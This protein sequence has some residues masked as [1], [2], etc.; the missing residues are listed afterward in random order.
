MKPKRVIAAL[1]F[2]VPC[3]IASCSVGSGIQYGSSRELVKLKG[4]EINE[5]SGLACGKINKGV[6]WTHNDSG[7]KPRIFAIDRSGRTLATVNIRNAKAVDWEDM[8]S[9]M[10]NGKS[11]LLLGDTGDNKGT[12]KCVTLYL[13]EEPK[14]DLKKFNRKLTI[15]FKQKINF[16]YADGPDDCEAVA[17]DP[18]DKVVAIVTKGKK[19]LYLLKLKIPAKPTDETFVLQCVGKLDIPSPT[20]MDISPDARRAVVVTYLWG[21]EYTREANESWA[22]AFKRSPQT[23]HLPLR[24]QGETI[25]FGP[26]GRNLYLT[27]EKTPTPLIEIP[28][29]QKAAPHKSPVPLDNTTPN[30]QNAPKSARESLHSTPQIHKDK[31]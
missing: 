7:D 25:C 12:R 29:K 30:K 23:I 14:L 22:D 1:F 28:A 4:K 8:C 16:T 19:Q 10:L 13:V 2:F 18:I 15:P 21:Y 5:S 27:S 31:G 20:G 11:Y 24:K 17:V 6:F 3:V 9:F 26:D